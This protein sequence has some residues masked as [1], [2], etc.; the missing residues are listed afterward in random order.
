MPVITTILLTLTVVLYLAEAI[1]RS[2]FK[3][4]VMGNVFNGT[5]V[6]I[7]LL[8]IAKKKRT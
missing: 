4:H 3:D 5:L 6:I 7:T 2:K 8:L 1:E